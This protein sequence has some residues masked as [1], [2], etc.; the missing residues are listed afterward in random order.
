VPSRPAA[1]EPQHV[2]I[3][4]AR[5]ADLAALIALENRVF[6]SD[7]MSPRQI[8]RHLGNPGAGTVV[9][10]R[11]GDVVGA[12]IVFFHASHRIARLYSIAVAPEARGAG[13]G[14]KLLAAAE[15]LARTRIAT[16]MRLEVRTDNAAAQRLYEG[17][18]Y[19]RFG[20]RR[21]YYEDGRD[22]VRYEKPLAPPRAASSRRAQRSRGR[23]SPS[24]P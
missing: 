22:A 13:I 16:A 11:N 2:R 20:V 17:R 23:V 1:S 12:A 7:R 19:R 15:R 24:R 8:R 5:D 21:R 3:R 10:T 4:R 6:T 9:A 14:E 18:G